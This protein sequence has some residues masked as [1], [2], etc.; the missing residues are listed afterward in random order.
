MLIAPHHK[1]NSDNITEAMQQFHI[2]LY[3]V[4]LVWRTFVYVTI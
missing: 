1:S 4:G 2:I 3:P